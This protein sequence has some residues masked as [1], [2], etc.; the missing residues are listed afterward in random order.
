[1]GR[2]H[3]SRAAF[4]RQTCAHHH[5]HLQMGLD[6][7]PGRGNDCRGSGGCSGRGSRSHRHDGSLRRVE[8]VEVA[9]TRLPVLP[10]Q[11]GVVLVVAGKMSV[12]TAGVGI[13]GGD[14]AREGHGTRR[15]LSNSAA[16]ACTR[17]VVVVGSQV[18][19]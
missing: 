10:P 4:Y 7:R 5:T 8:L 18:P 6:T 17:A 19:L 11:L 15:A 9:A 1:M 16:R 2:A 12:V 14:R 3:I 13:G